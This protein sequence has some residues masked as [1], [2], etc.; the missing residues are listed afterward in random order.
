VDCILMIPVAATAASPWPEY[1]T[2]ETARWRTRTQRR[3]AR[4][5]RRAAHRHVRRAR[6]TEKVE[7]IEHNRDRIRA[8]IRAAVERVRTR[9]ARP[10]TR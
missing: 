4:L 10:Q 6:Q 8:E 2:E 1:S 9:R 7:A 5:A 3:L